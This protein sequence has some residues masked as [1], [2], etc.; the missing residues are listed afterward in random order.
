MRVLR[1]S[2]GLSLISSL[3]LSGCV[4]I[5]S[6]RVQQ[7][8]ISD[9]NARLP[10]TSAGTSCL[11]QG[12]SDGG[13]NAVPQF[14]VP[15]RLT[16]ETVARI[17]RLA[18]LD[19]QAV[20]RMAASAKQALDHQQE[21]LPRDVAESPVV[22]KMFALAKL[23]SAEA[24]KANHQAAHAYIE[25]VK[26]EG[27]ARVA[28]NVHFRALTSAGLQAEDAARLEPTLTEALKNDDDEIAADSEQAKGNLK[29]GDF[30]D[31]VTNVREKLLTAPPP[32]LRTTPIISSG[33]A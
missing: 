31:L 7:T 17:N 33:I 25:D 18:P 29:R 3:M 26:A 23:A 28:N 22:K 14:S 21:T 4:D 30:V 16:P 2:I 20:P 5:N 13:G 19:A 10:A 24:I 12:A 27:G 6:M 32:K 11:L 8:A 1:Q 15:G 9:V